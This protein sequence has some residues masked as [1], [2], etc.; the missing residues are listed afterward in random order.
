MNL[1]HAQYVMTIL[2]CG[3]LSAAARKLYISQ[4]ALS[5]TL[6]QV[7]RELGSQVFIKSDGRLALTYAGERYID[8]ARQMLL[9]ESSLENELVEIRNENSGRFIFGIPMQQGMTLLPQLLP[10]FIKKYPNVSLDVK[11]NGSRALTGMVSRGMLDMALARTTPTDPEITYM[12]VYDERMV[13]IAGRGSKLF[14]R[15]PSGTPV[16]L[17]EAAD[18]AFVFLREGHNARTVQDDIARRQKLKLKKLLELDSYETAKRV[19]IACGA[20]MLS[21]YSILASDGDAAKSISVY[22]LREPLSTQGTFILYPKKLYIC[23][24]MRY[25]MQS[26]YRFYNSGRDLPV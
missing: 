18:D 11:E 24:Y 10:E 17:S 16:S 12:P 22:P 1:G 19:T 9:L 21:P 13:L 6:K 5:Q 25:W 15:L 14:E 3:S 8:T 4:S 7:E 26:I 20:V 2:E 23:A